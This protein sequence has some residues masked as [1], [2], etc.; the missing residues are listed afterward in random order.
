M[1][2]VR[3]VNDPAPPATAGQACHSHSCALRHLHRLSRASIRVS[4]AD[5]HDNAEAAA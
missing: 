4:P 1:D 5:A 3:D 2:L